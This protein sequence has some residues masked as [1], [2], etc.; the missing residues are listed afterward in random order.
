M[1]PLLELVGIGKSYGSVRALEQVSLSVSAGEVVAL[2]GDNGAGKSTTAKIIA[3][4]TAP[5]EGTV[6]F[7]G[8]ERAWQSPG[9]ARRAGVEMVYQDMGLA[10]HLSVA[11][12]IYLGQEL[13]RRGLL[14][15]LGFYDRETMAREAAEALARLHVNIPRGD[16]PVTALSGGQRQ[17]IAIA[18]AMTWAKK[19]LILDEPTNHLGVSG[20]KEVLEIIHKVGD[21]GVGVILISHTIP[22]VLDV[23]D[24]IVVLWQGHVTCVIPKAEATLEKVVAEITGASA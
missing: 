9:E 16:F 13:R 24:R 17:A 15:R 11:G 3:G 23:A 5:D 2:V 12:N 21:R 20:T 18:R 14:G 7:G 10:P 6:V 8:E 1:A 22:Q 4:A 19:L